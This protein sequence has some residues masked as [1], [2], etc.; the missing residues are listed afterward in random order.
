MHLLGPENFVVIPVRKSTRHA[1]DALGSHFIRH[2]VP[3]FN[4]RKMRKK[5]YYRFLVRGDMLRKLANSELTNPKRW[6]RLP[7]L[8]RLTIH[9]LFVMTPFRLR[10]GDPYYCLCTDLLNIYCVL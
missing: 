1:L 3:N 10:T 4:D 5:N 9:P 7:T 8:K 2:E 6:R